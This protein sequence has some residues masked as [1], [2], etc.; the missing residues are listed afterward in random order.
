MKTTVGRIAFEL[1]DICKYRKN[2][3]GTSFTQEQ[4]NLVTIMNEVEKKLGIDI[5]NTIVTKDGAYIT[6]K[7]KIWVLR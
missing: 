2:K 5:K 7:N 3:F 6:G 1:A 4:K